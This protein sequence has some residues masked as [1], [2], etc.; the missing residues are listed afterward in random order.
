MWELKWTYTESTCKTW[1]TSFIDW[2]NWSPNR[3]TYSKEKIDWVKK[4]IK[5]EW[6]DYEKAR[7]NAD[8]STTSDALDKILW[9]LDQD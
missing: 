7:K 8:R 5:N 9:I 1:N 3:W 6:V 2:V 4:Q